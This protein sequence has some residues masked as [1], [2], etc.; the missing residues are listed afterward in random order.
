MVA[1]PRLKPGWRMLPSGF[2]IPGADRQTHSVRTQVDTEYS[3]SAYVDGV[4]FL[5]CCDVPSPR[6]MIVGAAGRQ[7]RAIATKGQADYVTVIHFGIGQVEGVVNS[8]RLGSIAVLIELCQ[9]QR[10]RGATSIIRSTC[11]PA[12]SYW[13]ERGSKPVRFARKH[14]ASNRSHPVPTS[15]GRARQSAGRRGDCCASLRR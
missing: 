1:R 9:S 8:G 2:C 6:S 4:E 13:D 5:A 15:G 3:A 11:V 10:L 7:S 14:R 12:R